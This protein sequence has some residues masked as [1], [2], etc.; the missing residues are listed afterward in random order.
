VLRLTDPDLPPSQRRTALREFAHLNGWRPSDELDD[1][2]G[3]E[4][5]ANGHLVVEHGLDNSAVITF[6]HAG[7]SFW[8][9][10]R[11]DQN[12]LLS[13]SYN[14][15]VDWHVFPD[16]E[17]A[18]FV[19]N[20]MDPPLQRRLFLTDHADSWRIEAFERI[21]GRKPNPNVKNLEN[22]LMDTI[23][24][25]KR[26]LSSELGKEIPNDSIATLFNAIIFVRALEDDQFHRTRQKGQRLTDG[27]F[28]QRQK[29][30][31]LTGLLTDSLKELKITE[32][33][34]DLLD[35]KKL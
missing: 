8:A 7:N 4:R 12:R 20:R 25:W 29:G 14:N 35:R 18:T 26:A 11:S 19:Y 5:F 22:A 34:D 27:W 17:G 28:D 10:N 21:T 3:T 15:M 16:R 32:F 24:W 2:P 9:L 1:Y 30:G 13:I 33:P 31:D 23:S 6:L